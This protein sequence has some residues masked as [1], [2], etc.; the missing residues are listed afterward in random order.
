MIQAVQRRH[1]V[2]I[3]EVFIAS[4]ALASALMGCD[5]DEPPPPMPSVAP[6]ASPEPPQELVLEPEAAPS[7]EP[8][9]ATGKTGKAK[10]GSAAGS[11]SLAKCCGA[12]EQNAANA[13][14]PNA[15]YMRSAALVCRSALAAGQAQGTALAGIQAALKTA[16]MPTACQ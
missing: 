8:E 1:Q 12:L 7:A 6:A 9:A 10:G 3:A 2:G 11:G 13:P 14:E 5:K 16:G 15:A 4:A